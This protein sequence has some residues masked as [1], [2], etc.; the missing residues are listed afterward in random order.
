M[1]KVGDS[2]F[3]ARAY[4]TG[5]QT[6]SMV[7][8]GQ[9]YIVHKVM[10]NTYKALHGL[11]PVYLADLLITRGLNNCL[12]GANTLTLHQP[13]AQKRVGEGAFGFGAPHLWNRLRRSS[14]HPFP[15]H[16]LRNY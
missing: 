16:S 8:N 13:I 12:R 5:A 10:V 7:H 15:Y 11:A 9:T 14:V 3:H 1:W 6:T 2:D 4:H